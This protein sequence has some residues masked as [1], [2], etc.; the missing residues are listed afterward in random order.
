MICVAILP[1]AGSF[2]GTAWVSFCRDCKTRMLYSADSAPVRSS[3]M[4]NFPFS[5]NWAIYCSAWAVMRV[6][7]ITSSGGVSCSTISVKVDLPQPDCERMMPDSGL[8]SLRD[9]PIR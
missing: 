9:R 7:I 5:R 3:T 2:C 4:I 1:V 6:N 8:G